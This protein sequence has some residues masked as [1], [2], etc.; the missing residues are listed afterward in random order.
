MRRTIASRLKNYGDSNG[1]DNIIRICETIEYDE[2]KH[3]NTPLMINRYLIETLS[4]LG[5]LTKDDNLKEKVVDEVVTN[6]S[7]LLEGL[8]RVRTN[9]P[10]GW[11]SKLIQ[12]RIMSLHGYLVKALK[13]EYFDEDKALTIYNELA[14]VKDEYKKTESRLKQELVDDAR[15]HMST[16]GSSHKLPVHEGETDN[17]TELLGALELDDQSTERPCRKKAVVVFDEAG[18]IP[19]YELLGLSRLGHDFEAIL[20]VGDKHQLPPYDPSDGGNYKKSDWRSRGTYGRR[21]MVGER[22]QAMKSLL[23]VSALSVDEG[24]LMLTEQYRV[25]RDIAD[26]LNARIYNGLYN[27]S[28]LANV[29]SLGLNVCHVEEDSNP[30]K[31]YVNSHEVQYGLQLVEELSCDETIDDFLIITPVSAKNNR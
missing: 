8:I 12:R 24:K 2:K 9:A 17:I 15:L 25:P 10:D 29:P 16:I 22:K 21:N 14:Q 4:A 19:S 5:Q 20:L 28:P 30:R 3:L 27:T 7:A 1:I 11:N 23:N 31:K 26:M 13:E 6:H 18:C